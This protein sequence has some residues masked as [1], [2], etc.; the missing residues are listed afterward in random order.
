MRE[1]CTCFRPLL[2][3][4]LKQVEVVTPL[5][6]YLWEEPKLALQVQDAAQVVA[7]I[8]APLLVFLPQ[9]WVL[10]SS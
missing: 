10:S 4:R 2:S 3:L 1:T 7:F 9:A 5:L 8:L 6:Q